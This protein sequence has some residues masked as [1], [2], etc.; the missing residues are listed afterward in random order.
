M[1]DSKNGKVDLMARVALCIEYDG[2]RYHGWQTQQEGVLTI[3]PQVEQALSYV[4]NHSVEVV[5]AGRTDA[6]VH[7]FGQIAHFDS[8]AKRDMK[9]WVMGA[10]SNLPDDIS[11]RWAAQVPDDFHARFKAISRC[12]RYV[13]LNRP[14]RPAL[15][16]NHV[17]WIWRP[18]DVELMQEASQ[19]L[20]GEHDFSSFRGADCQAKTPVKTVLSINWQRHHEWLVMDIEAS[21]FLQHMVRNIVGTLLEVG[22][23]KQPVGWVKDVLDSCDRRCGG[24]TA[25]GNGLAMV[26]VGYP[27][28]YQLPKEVYYPEW[29]PEDLLN[30]WQSIKP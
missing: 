7:A 23:K 27:E 13:I 10:N 22:T 17:T 26:Q 21:G 30:G 12:Y 16:R 2:S 24:I 20:I 14:M 15:L 18:L 4:A 19:H 5:A 25:P 28:S 1:V 3:Q 6:G 8:L 9:A 11:V 29:L